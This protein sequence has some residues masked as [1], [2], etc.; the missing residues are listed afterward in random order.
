MTAHVRSA[1]ETDYVLLD[2]ARLHM[3]RQFYFKQ[4]KNI[5]QSVNVN[6]ECN[7]ITTGVTVSSEV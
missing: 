6:M 5:T 4:N 7:A 2:L 3:K 1:Q